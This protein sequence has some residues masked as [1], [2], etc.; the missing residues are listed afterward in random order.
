MAAVADEFSTRFD[1]YWKDPLLDQQRKEKN[2]AENGENK[3]ESSA[4]NTEEKTAPD[5]NGETDFS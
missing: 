2:S 4:W 5:A 3:D 1:P